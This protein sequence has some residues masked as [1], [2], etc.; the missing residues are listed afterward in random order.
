MGHAKALLFVNNE[1]SQ[2][3][4]GNILL[5]EAMSPYD[6]I[7]FPLFQLLYNGPLLPP[8]TEPAEGFDLNGVRFK[9]GPKGLKMLLGKH[10]RGD[11]KGYLLVVPHRLKGCSK[12]DF[13]LTIT[14]IAANQPVHGHRG[15]HVSHDFFHSAAL[16]RCLRVFKGL[17]KIPR[18]WSMWRKCMSF[19]N[20]KQ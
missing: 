8:R 2:V 20:F 3:L 1:Q 7:Y 9:A 17:F 4:K 13:C 19:L 6:N 14:N 12:R 11:K 18:V 16:I 15:P 5:Q 10:C